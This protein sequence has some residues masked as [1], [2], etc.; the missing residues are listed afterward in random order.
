MNH[1]MCLNNINSICY[2]F[3][4]KSSG[5]SDKKVLLDERC[6]SDLEDARKGAQRE[7]SDRIDKIIKMLNK[8]R[9]E[10]SSL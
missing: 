5:Y 4:G 7:L 1:N 2:N 9:E 10:L 3:K 6:L 8:K